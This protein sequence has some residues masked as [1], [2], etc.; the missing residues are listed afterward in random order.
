[1]TAQEFKLFDERIRVFINRLKTLLYE[2]VQA[3]DV[4]F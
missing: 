2:N 4:E 3:L 1:M